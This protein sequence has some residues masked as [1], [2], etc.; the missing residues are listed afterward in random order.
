MAV[1]KLRGCLKTQEY[2]SCEL[3]DLGAALMDHPLLALYRRGWRDWEFYVSP[4]IVSVA[5]NN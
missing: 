5:D 2:E 1:R 3:R 4:V